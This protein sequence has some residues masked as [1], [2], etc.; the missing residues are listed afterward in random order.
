MKLFLTSKG[1]IN[2]KIESAFIELLGKKIET[3]SICIIP[4]AAKDMKSNHP[5]II[6][7]K[8]IFMS[9]GVK[10]VD[11]LDIEME[12][13]EKLNKYD[14]IYIGGGDPVYLLEKL[15]SSGA[16]NILKK[17]AAREVVIIGVSAGSLVLGPH[18]HIV[19]WFTPNLVKCRKS[20]LK[21]LGLFDFPIMPHSDRKDIF[22]GD[23]SIESRLD[24]FE[25]KFNETV[26]RIKDENVLIIDNEK[27]RMI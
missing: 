17:L 9:L 8:G 19:E 16:D 15:R 20:N 1:L 24:K 7:A 3:S 21:G 23:E 25:I 4:T 26:S 11:C 6:Q 18:L 27:I 12:D 10:K 22:H 14:V 13:A 5:R 2:K